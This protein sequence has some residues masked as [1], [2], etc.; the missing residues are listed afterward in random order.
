M[1][2]HQNFNASN[3]IFSTFHKRSDLRKIRIMILKIIFVVHALITLAAGMVLIIVPELIPSTVN[4]R[5]D[6]KAYLLSYFLG[7]AEIAL[8]F[9]SFFATRLKSDEAIRLIASCFALFHFLTGATE[10]YALIRGADSGLW[11]NVALRAVVTLL[12]LYFGIYK[13]KNMQPLR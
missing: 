12:F 11:A 7:A 13:T 6:P 4:I 2:M 10:I 8:A 1:C 9:L 3:K 5:L